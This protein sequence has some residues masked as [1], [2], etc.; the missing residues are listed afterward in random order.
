[1]PA[2]YELGLSVLHKRIWSHSVLMGFNAFFPFNAHFNAP[3]LT[4]NLSWYALYLLQGFQRGGDLRANS[5]LL[6]T[7]CMLVKSTLGFIVSHVK[8]LWLSFY[9]AHFFTL[10]ENGDTAARS[11]KTTISFGYRNQK[12]PFSQTAQTKLSL[13]HSQFKP[14][15]N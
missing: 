9:K 15:Y 5:S 2:G 6:A 10:S 8:V 13:G 7:H 12:H 3:F 14:Y 1:M 4:S 11:F